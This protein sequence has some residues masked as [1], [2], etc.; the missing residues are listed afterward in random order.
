MK[1]IPLWSSTVPTSESAA[2]LSSS[3]SRSVSKA[4]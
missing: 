2:S 4:G 3:W 1:P